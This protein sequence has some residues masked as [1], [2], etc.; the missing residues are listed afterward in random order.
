MAE[1][2]IIDILPPLSPTVLFSENTAA[3]NGGGLYNASSSPT[4]TN[5]TFSGNT[6]TNNGGG[7]FNNGSSFPMLYNTVL[8]ANTATGAGDDINGLIN[9]SSSHNASDGT[10]GDIG[11]GNGFAM[12]TDDPFIDSTDPDGA[13]DIF[14]TADDG[15][16]PIGTIPLIDAGDDDKNEQETD[17]TGGVRIR[18]TAID[19]GAYEVQPILSS[20][21]LDVNISTI[22]PNPATDVLNIEV[23]SGVIEQ[24]AIYNLSG[25]KIMSQK[26]QGRKKQQLDISNLASGVYIIHIGSDQGSSQQKLVKQ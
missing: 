13:D 4:I 16:V 17:V 24:V 26:T 9:E 20:D 14:R 1:G 3:T 11:L 12:L 8:Y 6:T 25:E 18:G 2:C 5:S 23:H 19:I 22:H 15:L 7:I 21:I 10:G